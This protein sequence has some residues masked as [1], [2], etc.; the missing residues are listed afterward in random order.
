MQHTLSVIAL[1]M[2]FLTDAK[3]MEKKR[4]SGTMEGKPDTVF[5]RE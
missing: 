1:P 5:M 4:G 3:I 2:M